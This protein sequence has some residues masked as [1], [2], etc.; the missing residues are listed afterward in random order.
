MCKP[1][2]LQACPLDLTLELGGESQLD[3][4]LLN[5]SAQIQEDT[6]LR[7]LF[8][9][10]ELETLSVLMKRLI[11]A[12]FESNI[13]NEDVRSR[14]VMK[15]YALFELG[16]NTRHFKKIQAHFESALRDC[17]LDEKL[18]NECSMR[19]GALQS[20]FEEEGASLRNTANVQRDL[21]AK[22]MAATTA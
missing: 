8:K 5:F 1:V 9:H 10:F 11:D 7:T 15:H 21:S 19:F 16:I 4:L 12:A 18:L 3:F 6:D 20:I 17:W 14:I 13:L 22:I 2:D